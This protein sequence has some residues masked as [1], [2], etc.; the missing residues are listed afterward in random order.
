M[1]M[2]I[3]IYIVITIIIHPQKSIPSHFHPTMGFSTSSARPGSGR[4]ALEE[5]GGASIA[6]W[7][8]LGKIPKTD[9]NWG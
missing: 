9:E 2:Y 5:D 8:L 1:H 3:Y 7:F 6:G 4:S